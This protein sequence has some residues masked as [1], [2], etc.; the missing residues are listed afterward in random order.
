MISWRSKKLG[1]PSSS[2]TE[3]EYRA[4]LSASQEAQW[5]RKLTFDVHGEVPEKTKVWSDNQ[6]AIQLAK[7]PVFHSRTKHIGVHFN[8]TKDLITNKEISIAYMP[9]EEMIADI[10]TKALDREKHVKFTSMMGVLP[11]SMI[12]SRARG[13]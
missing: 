7:N 11:M 8:F 13:C 6:G 1:G 3:A 9:T 2:S 5:L 10:F 4:Y 12:V